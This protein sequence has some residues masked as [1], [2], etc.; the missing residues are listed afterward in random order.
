M[1]L[2]RH[3]RGRC[4]RGFS[5]A[6]R[7]FLEPCLL[8]I[9]HKGFSH[10][11][12]LISALKEFGFDNI[13]PGPVYRKL[14]DL[15]ALG[16]IRSEWDT[17]STVGAA[18]RVYKLTEDGHRYLTDLVRDLQKTNHII[19]NFLKSYNRHMEEGTGEY[20]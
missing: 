1:P 6:I 16:L 10:G 9:L 18:R 4:G 8:L 7:R 20:H 19:E 13:A 11:Y 3:R 2:A 15:E 5:G 12:K 14:R 17:D